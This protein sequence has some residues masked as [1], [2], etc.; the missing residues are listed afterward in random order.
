MS[1]HGSY[2]QVQYQMGRTQNWTGTNLDTQAWNETGKT[3][4]GGPVTSAADIQPL[5][6]IDRV[7]MY[8][9]WNPARL[10]QNCTLWLGS[11][12]VETVNNVPL[13]SDAKYAFY[14]PDAVKT[15]M[16]DCFVQPPD[17]NCING[18]PMMHQFVGSN[19]LNIVDNC[20]RA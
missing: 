2:F 19:T 12:N 4:T 10:I 14:S 8:S 15:T 13:I 5:D 11:T 1:L 16:S 6:S 17:G 18:T 20:S 3:V 9:H 7:I